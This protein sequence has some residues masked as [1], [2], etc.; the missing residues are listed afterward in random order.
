MRI[1]PSVAVPHSLQEEEQL[2]EQKVDTGI[3]QGLDD[4]AHRRY[5]EMS[6]THL[7]RLRRRLQKHLKE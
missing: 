3:S 4:V 6:P 5:T 1:I 2:R 7:E